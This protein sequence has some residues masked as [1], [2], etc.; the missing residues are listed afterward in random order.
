MILT[1]SDETSRTGK[2][3]EIKGFHCKQSHFIS[4]QLCFFS[5]ELFNLF[6]SRSLSL[7]LSRNSSPKNPEATAKL[8]LKNIPNS[9]DDLSP[10][11]SDHSAQ[12]KPQTIEE[13]RR[14]LIENLNEPPEE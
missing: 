2:T 14:I 3:E 7:S 12:N 9:I 13:I 6:P 11:N 4:R 10:N 5:A 1:A 8:S